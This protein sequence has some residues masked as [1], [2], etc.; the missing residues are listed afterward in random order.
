MIIMEV[1][2]GYKVLVKPWWAPWRPWKYVTGDW[3]ALS[4][5]E[6]EAQV[7]DLTA[8]YKVQDFYFFSRMDY[9]EVAL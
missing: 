1:K 9:Q 7:F 8:L 5:D 6:N 2:Q 3:Y 4:D